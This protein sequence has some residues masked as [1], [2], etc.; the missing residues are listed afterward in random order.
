MIKSR[1]MCFVFGIAVLALLCSS[2]PVSADPL[3]VALDESFPPFT[4]KTEAGD[5]AA[6]HVEITKGVID[7]A[8]F[9]ATFVSMK[10]PRVVRQTDQ[11]K[12]DVSIP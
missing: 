11:G 2:Y 1:G 5:M 12:L 7:L 3:R 9:E 4:Y 8:N 10:W 6:L